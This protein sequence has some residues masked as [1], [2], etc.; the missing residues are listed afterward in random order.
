[1]RVLLVVNPVATGHSEPLEV[2][3]A[4]RLARVA[5]VSVVRTERAGHAEE[6]AGQA[7]AS[8]CDGV[9]V[10]GG[11]GTVNETVNGLLGPPRGRTPHP[12]RTPAMG[13]LPAGSA[14]VFAQ[15]T[16]V[17]ATG[18]AALDLL[19]DAVAQRRTWRAGL[20]VV[21]LDGGA[22]RWLTFGASAG[23]DAEV[24]SQVERLRAAGRPATAGRYLRAGV[25]H[26]LVRADTYHARLHLEASDADGEVLARARGLFQVL[27]AS[28]A[29]WTYLGTRPV[30]LVP[31]TT[32]RTGLG[33][34]ALRS[35]DLPALAGVAGAALRR[36]GPGPRGRAVVRV[37][38]AEQVVVRAERP[39]AVQVDGDSSGE[40]V[41][42]VVRRA[43]DALDVMG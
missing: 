27:V 36:G 39:T 40:R 12:G 26:R 31:G 25:V 28:T 38:D 32:P 15:A 41:E 22:P 34:F 33:V 3:A 19:A 24:V 10:L 14:N 16:G 1:M 5:S 17:P 2:A 7:R 29:P 35:L 8:G 37:D 13:V 4:R 42:V 6:L 11:D 30:D 9:V 21:T 18:F 43:R 23:F 20:A